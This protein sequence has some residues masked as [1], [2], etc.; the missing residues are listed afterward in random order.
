MHAVPQ[1]SVQRLEAK[2]VLGDERLLPANPG[3]APR[4]P[5]DRDVS[6]ELVN[7]DFAGEDNRPDEAVLFYELRNGKMQAAYPVFVDGTKIKSS[8]Y[9]QEVDRRSELARLIVGS[10]YMPK[11]IVNR[12][13]AHFLGYGFTK[14]IDDIGPHNP[15]THPELLEALG[16]EFRM[17]SYDLKE[18]IRWIMLS[19]PYSLSSQYSPTNKKD[20]PA[21]GEKPMFSHFYLRQMRAE[22]LYESLLDRDRGPKDGRQLRR[23]GKDKLEWLKQFTI[24]FGTDENDETTTFNGTIPQTLM[25]MN[26]DLIKKAIGTD[27]G[28]FLE[29]VA[30]NDRLNNAAKINYLFL[31]ALSRRPATSEIDGRQRIDGCLRGG[32]SVAALQDVWWAV[33]N[34]NEFI[35]NH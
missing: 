21:L 22:E 9:L 2:S 10:D 14:P 20:D 27:K 34:S 6:V 18:L 4:R 11:A 32:D 3:D 12:L 8:G 33:L 25:M 29:Q 31:A 28:S 24:A 17:H 26:G 1:P 30:M 7:Q 19:E 13:W 35:L 16:K 5:K 23:A 15:P